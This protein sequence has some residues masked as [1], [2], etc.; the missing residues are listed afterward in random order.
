MD[1]ACALYDFHGDVNNGELTFIAG[2]VITITNKDVGEGWWEGQK[3]DGTIGLLPETYVEVEQQNFLGSSTA[4]IE[5]SPA[6]I[7]TESV[8]N[9]AF[10]SDA[11]VHTNEKTDDL[12]GFSQEFVIFQNE[13]S[14]LNPQPQSNSWQNSRRNT[15]EEDW[16]DEWDGSIAQPTAVV[17][18]L[19]PTPSQASQE[20]VSP[21]KRTDRKATV[22]MGMNLFSP[23]TKT[24]AESFVLGESKS[25]LS[26]ACHHKILIAEDGPTWELTEQPFACT[27]SDPVK[28]SKFSG[29][30]SFIAYRVMQSG[31]DNAVL[32]RF[33]HFDWL[34]EQLV[35]KFGVVISVPPLPDKQITGRYEED[36]IEERRK[37]LE[38]WINR[39]SL[40]PVISPSEVLQHFI[41]SQDNE[42]AWKA[43]KRKAEK[44]EAVSGAFLN[45]IE[46]PTEKLDLNL[47]EQLL[48]TQFKFTRS[49]DDACKQLIAH[50]IDQT[51]KCTGQYKRDFHKLGQIFTSLSDSFELDE[52]EVSK[53]LTA[54][55]KYTGD[56]Y[57]AI[58]TL[59]SEQPKQD[60]YPFLGGLGEYKAVLST[61]PN[62]LGN[63]KSA[64]DKNKEVRRLQL[65]N[66]VSTE[67]ME[68]ATSRTEKVSYAVQAEINHFQQF[69][70]GDFASYTKKFLEQQIVFHQEVVKKL[71]D[72]VACFDD[73]AA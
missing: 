40:H 35:R 42:K 64:L 5:Q 27:I 25:D 56:C 8:T 65:E 45:M 13:D 41:K 71:Q 62:I 67:E 38:L 31:T 16:S 43:G 7:Y 19:S 39:I 37:Q 1:T 66:K 55:M 63:Q 22:K 18:T 46:N 15:Q 36:F 60:W 47:A 29:L 57:I 73:L 48:D 58:G 70:V 17:K 20:P 21:I 10:L 3:A 51:K 23:F 54:A 4:K 52:R 44:D 59:F 53:P 68:A 28:E 49:M 6:E 34:Y 11:N 2:D 12:T 24:A 33:K 9:A 69:R 14:N 50:G 72:A 30:K 26:G 32:R 61:F